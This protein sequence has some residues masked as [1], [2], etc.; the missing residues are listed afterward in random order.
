MTKHR[1][2]GLEV[3]KVHA[4][5][6][7]D[8]IFS[9]AATMDSRLPDFQELD[10]WPRRA[11][12]DM[13]GT[14]EV[15]VLYS[16]LELVDLAVSKERHDS[17]STATSTVTGNL[18]TQVSVQNLSAIWQHSIQSE[19]RPVPPGCWMF[20]WTLQWPSFLL[21][22]QPTDLVLGFLSMVIPTTLLLKK[23]PFQWTTVTQE[24]FSHHDVAFTSTPVLLC[25]DSA[26]PFIVQSR[27]FKP[28]NWS[29]FI[30]TKARFIP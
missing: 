24:A 30:T 29:Y 10:L 20:T 25:P 13:T 23:T 4:V 15:D 16:I 19:L 6:G 2:P 28:N 14:L 5:V 8:S 7:V 3:H 9:V 18:K 17:P 12:Q 22:H 27:V 11:C 26:Q 1:C 21:L